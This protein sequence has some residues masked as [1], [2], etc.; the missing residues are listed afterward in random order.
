MRIGTILQGIMMAGL[1]AS[2]SQVRGQETCPRILVQDSTLNNL[3]DPPGYVPSTLGTL[4]GVIRMGT[5]SQPVILIPGLGFGGG[6]FRELM[7]ALGPERYRMYAVTL[8]GFGGTAAPP[9]PSETTSL[10]EQTW[11][12]G[13]FAAIERL[14]K[15][16]NIQHP[17]VVGHWLTGTQLAV[18]YA[19]AHPSDVKAVVLLAGAP[20]QFITDSAYAKYYSTPERRVAAVDNYLAP[21]WFKT[22]TRE[23]WDDNNFLPQDYAVDPVRGLRLWREAASPDLHVWIR[24]LCEFNAQDLTTE[25]HKVSVPTLLL[26]PGLEGLGQGSLNYMKDTYC[27]TSWGRSLEANPMITATTIARSRA[28]L[29]FDQ[30][31]VVTESIATFLTGIERGRG[32]G[33]AVQRP[34]GGGQRISEPRGE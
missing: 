26:K 32:R 22:V 9:C 7:D 8:P 14:V 1:I 28:C 33:A 15:E 29:W 25:M 30:P 31:K 13:A 5:G 18:R 4:G 12:N 23:T 2:A 20:R 21:R 16:E 6:V 10:G 3:V 27:H 19:L 17:I 34:R 11:T 24:Y